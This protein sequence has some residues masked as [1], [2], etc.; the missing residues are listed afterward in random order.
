MVHEI[1]LIRDDGE[2]KVGQ[3]LVTTVFVQLKNQILGRA[4]IPSRIQYVLFFFFSF[5]FKFYKNNHSLI[6]Q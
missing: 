1:Y 5:L 6:N 4:N 2:E 3:C